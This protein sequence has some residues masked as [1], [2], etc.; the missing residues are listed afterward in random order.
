MDDGTYHRGPSDYRRPMAVFDLSQ[1]CSSV[2]H[3]EPSFAKGVTHCQEQLPAVGDRTRVLVEFVPEPRNPYDGLAVALDVVGR[4]CGYVAARYASRLHDVVRGLN[5]SGFAVATRGLLRRETWDT[6]DGTRASGVVLDV[7]LPERRDLTV[8]AHLVGLRAAHDRVLDHL[9]ETDHRDVIDLCW[10]SYPEPLVRPLLQQAHRAPELTWRSTR[11]LGYRFPERHVSF[12]RDDLKTERER[13]ALKR[14]V[15]QL[16]RRR[17]RQLEHRAKADARK[18]ERALAAA[19][20]TA[21]EKRAVELLLG[22]QLTRSEV[23]AQVRLSRTEVVRLASALADSGAPV[24]VVNWYNN[25]QVAQRVTRAMIAVRLQ[26]IGLSRAQVGDRLGCGLETVG[27]L[28]ADGKAYDDPAT[29]A[30]RLNTAR[31][32]AVQMRDGTPKAS[33]ADSLGVSARVANRAC[34][35]AAAL[36]HLGLRD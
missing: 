9:C 14:K 1:E 21:A 22:G 36:A 2:V 30:T 17:V 11:P 6:Y 5:R 8:L 19:E 32:V 26:R 29:D 35:D 24:A 31:A 25:D 16:L 10:D 28:L 15:R 13:A 12:A 23:A 18:Q 3:G 34:R 4:R 7:W 33:I 27:D 20:R